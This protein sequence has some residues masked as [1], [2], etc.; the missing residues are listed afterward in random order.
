MPRRGHG[1]GSIFK[2]SDGRWA[3]TITLEGRRR[4]TFYGKTRRDVQEQLTVAL[5]ERQQGILATGPQQ[6]LGQFLTRWLEDTARPRVRPRTWDGYEQLV[7]L[8]IVPELGGLRLD[9]V[10]PQHLA[11]LYTHKLGEG[12]SP[13]RVQ[14]L[15][16][17]LHASLKQALRWNLIARNPADAVTAPKPKRRDIHALTPGEARTLLDAAQGDPLEALYVLALTTGMRQGEILGLRWADVDLAAGR[18][19][20]RHTLQRRSGTW[21]LDEPKTE[22]SRRSIALTTLAAEAL[23]HHRTRQLQARLLVGPEWQEHDLLFCDDFGQPLD[24]RS[25]LRRSFYPLLARAELPRI[26]F[27]D[28]RHS[29]ATLLL[30]QGVHP[31]IVQDLLGHSTIN[32]TMDTY[33]HVLPNLQQEA[34]TKMDA[35]FR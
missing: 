24:G 21:S 20:V 6:T 33:S 23:R 32:L 17:V 9:K 13:R 2:R 31:K 7:R 19:Q 26:R 11:W 1:E 25:L 15:H 3:A 4:K 29:A 35:L 30:T 5:R 14:Y 18:V 16:A 27:H 22:R 28:L 10:T 34:A 8:H 12:L